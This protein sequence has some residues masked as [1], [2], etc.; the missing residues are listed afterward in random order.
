MYDLPF[1]LNLTGLNFDEL[2]SVENGVGA[3]EFEYGKAI[4]CR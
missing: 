2:V 1:R 4:I 3:P